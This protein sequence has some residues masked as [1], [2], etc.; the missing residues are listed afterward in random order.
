MVIHYLGMFYYVPFLI[1]VPVMFCY[2][3]TDIPSLLMGLGAIKPDFGAENSKATVQLAHPCSMFS[4]FV[5]HFL[6]SKL[7]KLVICKI[8]L[9]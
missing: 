9:L 5:F 2:L 1:L 6:K 8:P 4:A 3:Y 7:V